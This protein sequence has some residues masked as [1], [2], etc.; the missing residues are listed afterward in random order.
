MVQWLGVS[1]A[2]P[3]DQGLVPSTL[4]RQ[5]TVAYNSSSREIHYL[6]PLRVPTQAFTNFPTHMI[7]NKSYKYEYSIL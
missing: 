3:E 2:L 1:T 4:T 7:K 6:W 5:L